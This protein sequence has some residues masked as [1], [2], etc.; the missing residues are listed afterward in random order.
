MIKRDRLKD[1][2]MKN[3]E[4]LLDLFLIHNRESKNKDKEFICAGFTM[5]ELDCVIPRSNEEPDR[6]LYMKI[7]RLV[8][9][10]DMTIKKTWS[11][12]KDRIQKIAVEKFI[13][14]KGFECSTNMKE[15]AIERYKTELF[16]YKELSLAYKSLSEIYEKISDLQ[17]MENV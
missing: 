14:A 8:G 17:K 11:V 3:I 1:L 12:L 6:E 5:Q 13:E 4:L 15:D 16:D 9:D 10:E 2:Q 7:T